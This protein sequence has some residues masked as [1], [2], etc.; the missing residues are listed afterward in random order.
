MKQNKKGERKRGK[1]RNIRQIT[2][3][4][5]GRNRKIKRKGSDIKATRRKTRSDLGRKE[6]PN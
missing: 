4:E 5:G 6:E 1:G 3:K 2:K